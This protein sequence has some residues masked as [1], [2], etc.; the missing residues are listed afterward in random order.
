MWNLTCICSGLRICGGFQVA[1]SCAKNILSLFYDTDDIVHSPG[2]NGLEGGYPVRLN[3][4]GAEVVLPKGISI[5]KAREIN[6]AAQK[7]DG[8]EEI[9]NN[10]DIVVTEEAYQTFKQILNIDCKKITIEDSYDQALE[11]KKKLHEF[12]K[13]NNANI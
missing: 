1:A 9:S 3:R 2:P 11:L 13:K 4:K 8:I 7:Y 5:E 10:G 12:V 6:T